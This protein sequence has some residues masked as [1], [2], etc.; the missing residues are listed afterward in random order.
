MALKPLHWHGSLVLLVF[1]LLAACSPSGQAE[2]LIALAEHSRRDGQLTM[3]AELYH[4]AAEL[5]PQHFHTHYRTVLWW[6]GSPY[7]DI[8]P[9]GILG[10]PLL[11][12]SAEKTDDSGPIIVSK[13][14]SH[15]RR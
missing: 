11:A 8:C 9:A 6:P 10:G 7:L 1:A 5:Q 14:T 2:Q 13:P 3:A 4:R 15:R 12:Q